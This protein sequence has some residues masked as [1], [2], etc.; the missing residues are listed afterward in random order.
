MVDVAPDAAPG[1]AGGQTD[2]DEPLAGLIPGYA[3]LTVIGEPADLPIEDAIELTAAEEIEP[4]GPAP[5]SEPV[6]VRVQG[7]D[8][9]A[10]LRIQD[11]IEALPAPDR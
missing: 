6:V 11:V 2:D 5:S 1:A 4:A 8:E 9:V 10:E 7:G 3:P